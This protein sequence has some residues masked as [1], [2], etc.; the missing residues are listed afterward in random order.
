MLISKHNGDKPIENNF[1]DAYYS[2]NGV[3][4]V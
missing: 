4:S 1:V 2:C 3:E